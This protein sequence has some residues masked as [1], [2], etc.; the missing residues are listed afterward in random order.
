[1]P[2]AVADVAWNIFSYVVS[3]EGTFALFSTAGSDW[4]GVEHGAQFS[5]TYEMRVVSVESNEEAEQVTE[6]HNK[7]KELIEGKNL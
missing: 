1:M 4:P 3:V 5:L 7:F 6:G 2:I